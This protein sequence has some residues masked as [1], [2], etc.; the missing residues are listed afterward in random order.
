MLTLTLPVL[1]LVDSNNDD[2]LV[3][4]IGWLTISLGSFVYS[5]FFAETGHWISAK[6]EMP[7]ILVYFQQ[8]WVLYCSL[9]VCF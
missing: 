1:D 9:S 5:L 2:I 3:M 6:K 4:G 8:Y 7:E